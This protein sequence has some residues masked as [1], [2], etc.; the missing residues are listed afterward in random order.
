MKKH[1]DTIKHSILEQVVFFIPA[2]PGRMI[3]HAEIS[4]A[5]TLFSPSVWVYMCEFPVT[6]DHSDWV[7]DNE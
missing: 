1:I 4:H 3:N 2:D 6:S 7:A 5:Q